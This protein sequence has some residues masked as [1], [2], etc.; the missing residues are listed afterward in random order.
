MHPSGLA[1]RGSRS[2]Q[3]GRLAFPTEAQWEYL[4]RGG[5]KTAWTMGA[6]NNDLIRFGNIGSME[7]PKKWLEMPDFTESWHDG[8]G[9]KA[10][11]VGRF[12]SNSFALFDV[13]RNLSE[14]CR[15]YYFDYGEVP[16]EKG[17]GMRPG[18]SG[19][20]LARGGNPGG[21]GNHGFGFRPSVDLPFS[22]CR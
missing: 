16:A 3:G 22:A 18:N 21:G 6:N 15:D 12:E 11:P 1:K 9:N 19:K 10:A 4:C 20:R 14:W 17:T 5:T 7:C 2:W 8:Y 13:H